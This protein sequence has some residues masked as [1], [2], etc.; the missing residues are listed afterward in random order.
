MGEETNYRKEQE[1]KEK[2]GDLLAQLWLSGP[3][4][5]NAYLVTRYLTGQREKG[6][7]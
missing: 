5:Q 4:S 6:V 3:M 2:V 1:K 7:S